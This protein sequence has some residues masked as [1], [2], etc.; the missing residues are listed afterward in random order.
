VKAGRQPADGKTLPELQRTGVAEAQLLWEKVVVP[1]AKEAGVSFAGGSA[2]HLMGT[3]FQTRVWHFY[4]LE[5]QWVLANLEER[6]SNGINYS[7]A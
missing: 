7:V 6:S 2:Q 5:T 1:V 3:D 4:L